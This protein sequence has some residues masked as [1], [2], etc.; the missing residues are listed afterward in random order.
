MKKTKRKYNYN[1]RTLIIIRHVNERGRRGSHSLSVRVCVRFLLRLC[2]VLSFNGVN[3]ERGQGERGFMHIC[4]IVAQLQ[5]LALLIGELVNGIRE[6]RVLRKKN[7][8]QLR[9]LH[10]TRVQPRL[11]LSGN[12]TSSRA[13]KCKG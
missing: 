8:I 4:S 5:V 3:D 9:C 13:V 2:F 12:N 7:N 10:D 6:V 11:R 1:I